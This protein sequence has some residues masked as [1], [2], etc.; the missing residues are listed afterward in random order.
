MGITEKTSPL[1]QSANGCHLPGPKKA[2]I[3]P[4]NLNSLVRFQCK[5]DNAELVKVSALGKRT[6]EKR[7]GVK[8]QS[9]S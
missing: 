1:H 6:F 8:Q 9:P 3:N 7:S 2:K 4:Q 5:C